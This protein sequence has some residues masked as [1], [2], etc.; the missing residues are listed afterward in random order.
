MGVRATER[1]RATPDKAES[2]STAILHA[3]REPALNLITGLRQA[4][5][6]LCLD[7]VTGL[8]GLGSGLTP[9]GD[10]WLVG[11]MLAMWAISAQHA[12]PPAAIAQAAAPL[13]T[14]L[15]AAWLHA[16]ARGECGV[17]WHTLI[18]ALTGSS[19][20]AIAQAAEA[21][22]HQGHTS[23]A[24]ALSGFIASLDRK[25]AFAPIVHPG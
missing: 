10:D 13:T 6:T 20:P 21:V 16:A 9:S 22:I 4:D 12:I 18:N 5:R 7:G 23:G 25:C 11:C 24:D 15:S 3:A 17:R 19:K 2:Y 1:I 8:A 14:P